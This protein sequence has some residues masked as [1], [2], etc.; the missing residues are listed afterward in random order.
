MKSIRMG[1][2]A[3]PFKHLG[4][5]L[6]HCQVLENALVNAVLQVIQRRHQRQ[7]VTRQ[8][9][10]GFAH[11]HIFNTAMNTLAFQAE[12]EKR[13]LAEQAF[14]IKI[15][16]LAH[17]LHLDRIQRTDRFKSIKGKHFEIVTNIGNRQREMRSIGGRK[18]R[19]VLTFKR[20]FL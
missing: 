18:H 16:V 12:L 19:F 4:D 7:V 9:F 11:S 20:E 1:L 15:R 17:Q 10:T 8:S 2:N 6:R 14:Q 3:M 5:N 13:W